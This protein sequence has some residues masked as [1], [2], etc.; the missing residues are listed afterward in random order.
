MIIDRGSARA[1]IPRDGPALTHT[2]TTPNGGKISE[3]A[4]GNG[5]KTKSAN[6]VSNGKA[7][8]DQRTDSD[9]TAA[10][11]LEKLNGTSPLPPQ[12]ISAEVKG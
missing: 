5:D 8:L 12:Q 9:K 7:G 11:L 10:A 2:S 1:S 3:T 4:F 6:G